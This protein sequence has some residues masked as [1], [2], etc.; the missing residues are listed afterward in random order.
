MQEKNPQEK[1]AAEKQAELLINAMERAKENGGVWLN[2]SEKTAR[3]HTLQRS[4]ET[5]RVCTVQGKGSSLQL[6]QLEGVC[7]QA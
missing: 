3:V 1:A 2:P 4:Q 7:Q 5:R 6:V